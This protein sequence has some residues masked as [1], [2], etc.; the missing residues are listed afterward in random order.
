MFGSNDY[1]I[2]FIPDGSDTYLIELN[3]DSIEK[4]KEK[5]KFKVCLKDVNSYKNKYNIELI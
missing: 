5:T 1:T 4:N 2:T 3:I